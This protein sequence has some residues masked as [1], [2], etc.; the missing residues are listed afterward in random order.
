MVWIGLYFL[1]NIQKSD[2]QVIKL[3]LFAFVFS[4]F[5]DIFLIF[6]DAEFRFFV[7]GLASF[8]VAQII[9]IFLFR[10]TTNLSGKPP[11][12]KKKVYWIFPYILFGLT[13]YILLFEQLNE[14]LRI[15][16]F[17]YMTALLG[18]SFMALNRFGKSEAS[19]FILVFTG[20]LF[21]IF[22]DTII[23][24]NKFIIPVRHEGIIVMSCYITAQYLI[25]R[26]LLK[27]YQ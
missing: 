15:A 4:W 11:F 17:I 13:I 26:G 27:Q 1:L 16:V 12:L 14:I 6:G 24:I 25:M 9:Y 3:A 5:G 19:S 8:L 23:A 22:S 7:F 20:S 21:F 10:K 18:M 2:S